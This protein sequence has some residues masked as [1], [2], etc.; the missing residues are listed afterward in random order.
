MAQ[1]NRI[2]LLGARICVLQKPFDLVRW[3]KRVIEE[4]CRKHKVRNY[5]GHPWAEY[6]VR[7]YLCFQE[8]CREYRNL[9]VPVQVN[10]H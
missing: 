8:N 5:R 3:V 10:L 4:F 1:L 7:H 9:W 6:G 2:Y